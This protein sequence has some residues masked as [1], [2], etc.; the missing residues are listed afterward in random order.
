MNIVLYYIDWLVCLVEIVIILSFFVL[1][2]I[3]RESYD[4]GDTILAKTYNPDE[5]W[6]I[7]CAMHSQGNLKV[8]IDYVSS[9]N[10][11][12]SEGAVYSHF[13]FVLF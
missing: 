2:I 10:S 5:I 9:Y 8:V 3:D 6:N 13:S 4:V 12:L 1:L 11:G 7:L